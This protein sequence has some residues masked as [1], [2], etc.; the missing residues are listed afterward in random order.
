MLPVYQDHQ[1]FSERVQSICARTLIGKVQSR[2]RSN[3][4]TVVTTGAT[5]FFQHR[6]N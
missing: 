3:A 1:R 6:I 2:G 5:G 4:V